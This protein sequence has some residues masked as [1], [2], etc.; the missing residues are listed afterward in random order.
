MVGG[1]KKVL[2]IIF[3]EKN[4]VNGACT[5]VYHSL[6]DK[7]FS[8]VVTASD[9]ANIRFHLAKISFID[10]KSSSADELNQNCGR[11]SFK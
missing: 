9:I 11:Y 7:I 6:G 5:G 8:R 4:S 2:A 10:R 1:V 3:R